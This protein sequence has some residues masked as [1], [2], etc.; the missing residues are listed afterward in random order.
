M[1]RDLLTGQKQGLHTHPLGICAAIS[2]HC[3]TTLSQLYDFLLSIPYIMEMAM[4]P[5]DQE[6]SSQELD[7]EEIARKI[8]LLDRWREI[9]SYHR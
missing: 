2:P 3:Q 1:W 8:S 6:Q 4:E 7:L 5:L 9:F